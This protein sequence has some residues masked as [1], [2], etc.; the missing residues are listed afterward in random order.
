M[1]KLS[2]VV[3]LGMIFG[4]LLDM[5]LGIDPSVLDWP[6]RIHSVYILFW[7]VVLG[8]VARELFR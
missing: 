4:A 6:L 7:G 2:L 8:I 5:A 3:G 1:A